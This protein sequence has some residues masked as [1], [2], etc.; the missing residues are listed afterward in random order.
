M[1]KYVNISSL[2]QGD[3]QRPIWALNGSADSEIG[4]PGEVHVGIPKLNGNKVDNL[5]LPQTWLP[6]CLT[7]QIP[8]PQLLA[9]SEFRNAVNNNLIVLISEPF[10]DEIQQQEG[11]REERSRLAELRRTIR[12]ATSARSI[13]TSNADVVRAEDVMDGTTTQ[14]EPSALTPGF[15]MFANN[16]SSKTDIAALN[17][18]RGRG[19]LSAAETK[20]L[21]KTLQDK[22]KSKEF[23]KAK[24]KK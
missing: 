18:I 9:S 14:E 4:Q 16:L 11:V 10:A 5:Y 23:L 22:P 20:H 3:Q 8:R 12:E 19:N 13:Q 21:I 2:E 6:T 1:S 17:L 15:V 7:D 24:R